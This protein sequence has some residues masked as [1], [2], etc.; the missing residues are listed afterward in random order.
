M[1]TGADALMAK[2]KRFKLRAHDHPQAGCLQ[3]Q[4]QLTEAQVPIHS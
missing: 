2:L 1:E 3:V 4:H